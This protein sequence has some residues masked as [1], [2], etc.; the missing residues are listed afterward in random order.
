MRTLDLTI[1]NAS[2]SARQ[3]S[4]P[5]DSDVTVRTLVVR[6][7]SINEEART[8][9]AVVATQRRTVAFD[10][11]RWA[12]V[13]EILVMR[14]VELPAD[15]QIILLDSHSATL[16]L[17]RGQSGSI[18]DVRGSIRNL[19]AKGSE[20]IG[21]LHF[22]D[23]EP[24]ERAWQKVRQGHITDISGGV[25]ALSTVVI[26]P[27]TT[28]RIDGRSY[29]AGD[30]PLYVRTRWRPVEGSLVPIGADA[31]AKIRATQEF[32]SMDPKLRKHLESI[33]LRADAPDQ[34]AEEF[35]QNLEGDRRQQADT[36]R[37]ES[38][39]TSTRSA[40]PPAADPPTPAPAN[41]ITT[42]PPASR[43][44][45]QS[46]TAP[47]EATIRA[48]AIRADAIRADAI[49]AEEHARQTRIRE[50][51]ELAGA[52]LPGELVTRAID[53]FWAPERASREFLQA[54]RDR[55]Q[56]PVGSDAP[57]GHVR[58]HEADCTRAAMGAAMIIRSGLDP[59][60]NF[61]Q[62]R[63]GC[64]V[65]RREGQDTTELERAADLGQQ[66]GDLS[67]VDVCREACRL[68]G[69]TIPSN[70][71]AVI[72]AAV[73][74][75]SLSAIFTTNINA[76]LLA[77]YSDATD[78][79][80]GWTSS[81]DVSDFKT[82][83]RATMGKFGQLT[84]HG[85]TADHLDTSDS[86]EEYKIARY[87]GQFVV[88]EM[89]IVNDRW[90][91]IER[92][93]PQ[94]MGQTAAQLR[95]NLV[96]AILLANAAL[97]ADSIALFQAATHKNYGTTSTALAAAT[98]QAGITALGKQRIRKRPLNIRSRF[99][100]VP[101]DLQWTAAVLLKS[102]Q[103]IISADSGGTYNPLLAED[104][105]LRIDDRIGVAGCTDPDTE[106]A[107][108]GSATNW[109]LSARP[110]E[111]GAKTIEVGYLRGTGRAP[112]IRPFVLDKGEWGVG[113]DIKQDIGAKALDFRGMY[114]AT[115][116]GA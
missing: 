61:A 90:G 46:S 96:Y 56:P 115:G 38:Q 91:A 64:Y 100:L 20:L 47:D 36:I 62:F 81:S 66:Y 14:G 92:L 6:A 18:E 7:D 31:G 106:T 49:R 79:T 55:R 113:W 17:A 32:Q 98:L 19:R 116:A 72:R 87:S 57:A 52:D 1:R 4:M 63:D 80:E 68:D 43:L 104:I 114:K 26:E 41:T 35:F 24:S 71:E 11:D 73:S 40:P 30:R 33:G 34:E 60:D 45:E 103:R 111:N 99:L 82:N 84:K 102:A 12:P 44:G 37:A 76:Q 95:P 89:D 21:T 74:G 67:L 108:A 94:D 112:Q 2:S 13:E 5:Q 48:D 86:K 16:D 27:N 77:G 22:A 10:L 9:E 29:R 97:G 8:V 15:K 70:R 25:R 83:E 85:R 109:F 107:Y 53:G 39:Q 101:Q 42:D 51:A 69:I 54:R 3:A 88:D 93:S 58:S 23:D 50:L 78:T 105:D 110:G 75:S 65:P 59:V 28:E